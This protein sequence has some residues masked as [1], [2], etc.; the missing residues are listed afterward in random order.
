MTTDAMADAIIFG[1]ILGLICTVPIAILLH[2]IMRAIWY[3]KAR[4]ET[5][6]YEEYP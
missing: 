5:N 6:Y 2:F 1:F 3:K 4:M